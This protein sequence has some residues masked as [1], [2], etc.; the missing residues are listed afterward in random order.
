MSDI[1]RPLY[2]LVEAVEAEI[3]RLLPQPEA[4]PAR[5][6]RTTEDYQKGLRSAF[7]DDTIC[8]HRMPW[9]TKMKVL[10]HCKLCGELHRTLVDEVFHPH[11]SIFVERLVNATKALL[12]APCNIEL[13]TP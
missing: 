11:E 13:R 12:E 9:D 8:L 2:V 4:A 10:F 3:K 7:R 1:Y 5:T 6:G